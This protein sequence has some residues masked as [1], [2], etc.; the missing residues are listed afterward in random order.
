VLVGPREANF[1][2]LDDYLVL[3]VTSLAQRLVG[4]IRTKEPMVELNTEKVGIDITFDV[5]VADMGR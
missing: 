5:P 4:R 1:G 2:I 3:E